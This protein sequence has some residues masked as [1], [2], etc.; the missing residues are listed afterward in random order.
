MSVVFFVDITGRVGRYDRALFNALSN[1]NKDADVTLKL[2]IPGIHL[3][4]LIPRKFNSSGF[5]LK[6]LV[7]IIEGILNYLVLLIYVLFKKVTTIHFQWFPF[8]DF[9]G[10]EVYFLK[11]LRLILPKINLVL[12]IH[13]VYPH[14]MSSAHKIKYKKR[15]AKLCEIIDEI[16][17]HTESTKEDVIN[18]FNL[19]KDKIQVVYH[20]VFVPQYKTNSSLI[21]NK[22]KTIILQFGIQSY[23][24]GPD[25]LIKA[26]NSLPYEIRE[27]I[28]IRIVGG[29]T[30][31]YLKQ[32]KELDENNIVKFKPYYL[33]DKELH[34]EICSCDMIVL[35][36][37]AISQSGVLLLSLYYEKIIVTS[38]L[39]SFKET[40]RTFD[41]SMF[42]ENNN[43][44]SLSNLLCMY[45]NHK[46]NHKDV[47]KKIKELKMLYS[48]ENAALKTLKI[49][50]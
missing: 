20:G 45:L 41:D 28:E 36:Y 7:K 24:K 46:I 22:E 38:N 13:N 29:I 9:C 35:P 42:F 8:M 48:W 1:S 40:L 47:T 2:L 11:L 23:Y 34:D 43:S 49:Y 4:R 21:S 10:V 14:N 19:Q 33:S 32:L 25:L 26:A 16:I 5:I 44:D 50:N 17:V 39:P 6:R 27:K 3:I 30:P 37:R 12:T 18:E 15:F 31:D